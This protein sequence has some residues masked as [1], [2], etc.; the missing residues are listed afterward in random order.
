MKYSVLILIAAL[1]ACTGMANR[2]DTPKSKACS[3]YAEAEANK[4]AAW[5]DA[6]WAVYE[7]NAYDACMGKK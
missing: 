5:A 7:G 1:S 2:P 4:K 3:A 6:W